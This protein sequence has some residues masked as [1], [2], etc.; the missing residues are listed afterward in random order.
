MG[1]RY[2]FEPDHETTVITVGGVVRYKG[3]IVEISP[4]R[5]QILVESYGAHA[6]I[7]VSDDASAAEDQPSPESIDLDGMSAVE[8]V[9]FAR[10]RGYRGP[11]KKSHALAYLEGL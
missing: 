6:L 4:E 10:S 2:R 9:K 11:R 3:E 7:L 8:I 1:A 5:A